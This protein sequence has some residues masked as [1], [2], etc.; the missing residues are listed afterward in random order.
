[1][2]TVG[3]GTFELFYITGRPDKT[4]GGK[5]E[6]GAYSYDP[7]QRLNIYT[8]DANCPGKKWHQIDRIAGMDKYGIALS[9][10]HKGNTD[11]NAIGCY[12]VF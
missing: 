5:I 1:M 8:S 10:S 6:R 4:I 9:V 3:Q 12:I 7:Q 11:S 2:N